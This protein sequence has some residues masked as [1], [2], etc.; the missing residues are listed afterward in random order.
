MPNEVGKLVIQWGLAH[1]LFDLRLEALASPS[2]VEPGIKPFDLHTH[3]LKSF[4]H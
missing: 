4:L 3:Q 1:H 2:Q